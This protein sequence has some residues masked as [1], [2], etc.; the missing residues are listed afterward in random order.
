[1][2][3]FDVVSQANNHALDYG[4]TALADTR[5]LVTAQGIDVVGAGA[6]VAEAT[7][8]AIEERN[9]LRI[10]FLGFVDTQAEGSYNETNW[11][12][13]ADTPGVAWATSGAITAAVES[14]KA[15]ADLVVVMLHAGI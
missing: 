13:T 3:G 10:A 9:G 15:T 11:A 6:D 5:R 14:A 1:D 12:A 2:A 8:P 7:A 4:P